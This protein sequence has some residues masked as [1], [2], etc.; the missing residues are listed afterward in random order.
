MSKY[1]IG[2]Y[3]IANYINQKNRKIS[4]QTL[5]NMNTKEVINPKDL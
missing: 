5:V 1:L 3:G 4:S 2:A